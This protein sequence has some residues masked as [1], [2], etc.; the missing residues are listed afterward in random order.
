M[1]AMDANQEKLPTILRDNSK[2]DGQNQTKKRVSFKR[3]VVLCTY[4]DNWDEGLI[5]TCALLN[6][7]SVG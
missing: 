3:F 1:Y 2:G 5:Q 7:I 6:D 4:P